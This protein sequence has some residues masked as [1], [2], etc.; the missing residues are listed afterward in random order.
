[1]RKMTLTWIILLCFVAVGALAQEPEDQYVTS[2]E[3]PGELFGD[4]LVGDFDVQI[5]DR[6]GNEA[7]MPF[8]M[9]P[10]TPYMWTGEVSA[11]LD[12]VGLWR[13]FYT[14]VDVD[15]DGRVC[16]KH[17][18][19]RRNQA[20]AFVWHDGV[21]AYVQMG[22]DVNGRREILAFTWNSGR[23]G[24]LTQGTLCFDHDLGLVGGYD[25]CPGALLVRHTVMELDVEPWWCGRR[26]HGPRR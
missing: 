7:E 3:Y 23:G 4:F 24:G 14:G 10:V 6:D 21:H 1:M 13:Y 26:Y 25:W 9:P 5:G 12:V 22:P 18:I 16:I 11:G 15:E 8:G 2:G 17:A 19:P 20:D